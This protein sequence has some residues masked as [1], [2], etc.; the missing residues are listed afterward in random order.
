MDLDVAEYI[1]VGD[2][3]IASQGSGNHAASVRKTLVRMLQEETYG[4]KFH[5][6][7]KGGIAHLFQDGGIV[8]QTSLSASK[9]TCNGVVW[10]KFMKAEHLKQRRFEDEPPF[11]YL[12]YPA[13]HA[14][15]WSLCNPPEVL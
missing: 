3:H 1:I 14:T 13:C 15:L 5:S 8:L 10:R 11:K 2:G 12:L 4:F 6:L 9:R 7:F